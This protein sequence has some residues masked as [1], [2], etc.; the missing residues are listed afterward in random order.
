MDEK[1]AAEV[2]RWVLDAWRESVA[3]GTRLPNVNRFDLLRKIN[4]AL[5]A[6]LPLPLGQQIGGPAGQ[7]QSSEEMCGGEPKPT[8]DELW[9]WL[10]ITP[11]PHGCLAVLDEGTTR[12]ISHQRCFSFVELC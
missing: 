10:F 8:A 4:P 6:G 5:L 1:R 9:E 12:P 11:A 3:A 7:Q 2:E